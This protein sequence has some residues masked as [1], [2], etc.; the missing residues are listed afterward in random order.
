MTKK[1]LIISTLLILLF[2]CQEAHIDNCSVKNPIE[3]L[4]WL[5]T[6]ISNIKAD[7]LISAYFYFST[8]NYQGNTVFVL[9]DCCP[10]CNTIHLVFNCSGKAIGYIS[11]NRSARPLI[12]GGGETVVPI[13]SE[14]LKS[15]TII[16]KPDSLMCI[17]YPE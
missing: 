14:I 12:L 8:V 15:K 4:T 5:N 10:M 9:Q 7:T 13:D 11:Y 2:S 1:I 6:M 17:P 16:W 3:Q